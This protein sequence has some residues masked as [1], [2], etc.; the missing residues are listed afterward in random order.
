MKKVGGVVAAQYQETAIFDIVRQTPAF[1]VYRMHQETKHSETLQ[2]MH[3]E[4]G[5]CKIARE[6]GDATLELVHPFPSG[7]IGELAKGI[8]NG[9]GTLSLEAKGFQRAVEADPMDDKRLSGFKRVYSRKGDT[10]IYDQYLSSGGSD[11]FHHLHC[12][13]ELQK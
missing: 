8:L 3:T 6:T 9:D 10:L 13:L 11:L 5:F 4:T 7:M 1:V 12:E 2:P